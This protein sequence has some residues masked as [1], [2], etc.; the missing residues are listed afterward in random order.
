MV[1]HLLRQSYEVRHREVFD[2]NEC[3]LGDIPSITSFL[4][5]CS[6]TSEGRQALRNL[7]EEHPAVVF[8]ATNS[9]SR[10]GKSAPM[11]IGSFQTY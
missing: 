2:S 5:S 1:L 8:E 11:K 3:G 7:G 4:F 10:T 9:P 6:R